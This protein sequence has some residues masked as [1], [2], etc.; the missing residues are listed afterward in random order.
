A[1]QTAP[2]TYHLTVGPHIKDTG[3]NEMAA[4]FSASFTVKGGS[5]SFSSGA[6]NVAILDF[7]TATST[8]NVSQ[9]LTVGKVT[10]NVNLIHTWVGD[11]VIKL[12]G[13]NGTT[14]TLFNRHGGSGHNLRATFDDSAITPIGAAAAPFQGS[15]RPDQALSTFN[16]TK[17]HG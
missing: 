2:G 12:R 6:L 14:I 1:T 15:F 17:A 10:V 4:A 13:P 7:H 5:T 11:R 8:I 16:G 9:D 3:G